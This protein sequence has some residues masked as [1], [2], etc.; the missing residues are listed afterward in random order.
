MIRQLG[1]PL[2][3][4]VHGKLSPAESLNLLIDAVKSLSFQHLKKILIPVPQSEVQET[5]TLLQNLIG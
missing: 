1:L 2:L 4:S 3:G 5:T